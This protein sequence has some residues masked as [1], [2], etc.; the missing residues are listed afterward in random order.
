MIYI[1]ISTICLVTYLLARRIVGELR[2]TT[3]EGASVDR[4]SLLRSLIALLI[5]LLGISSLVNLLLYLSNFLS[6]DT[7][8]V[9]LASYI[10]MIIGLTFVILIIERIFFLIKKS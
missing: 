3:Q 6:R 1:I 4:Y 5:L 10:S 2:Q 9:Y 8:Y 7:Y